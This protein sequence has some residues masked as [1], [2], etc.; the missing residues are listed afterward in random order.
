MRQIPIL[1]LALA[2]TAASADIAPDALWARWQSGNAAIAA[3]EGTV[4]QTDAGLVVEGAVL[5]LGRGPEAPRLLA[6]PLRLTAEDG[7]TRITPPDT[8]RIEGADAAFEVTAPELDL[9]VSGTAEAP[10]YRIEEPMLEATGRLTSGEAAT[11]VTLSADDLLAEI[12]PAAGLVLTAAD[13][14]LEVAPETGGESLSAA[15][16]GL[17]VAFE[18]PPRAI[19]AP[20]TEGVTY[21]MSLASEASRH[22]LDG[23]AGAAG[24]VRATIASGPA[25]SSVASSEARI[26]ALQSLSQVVVTATGAGLPLPEARVDIGALSL[27]VSTP[28]APVTEAA[29]L[30]LDLAITG[31]SPAEEIWQLLDPGAALPRAPAELRLSVTGDLSWL[32]GTDPAIP[33]VERARLDALRLSALGATLTG[34]GGVQFQPPATPETPGRPLGA[35]AFT[36]TGA[37]A[38]LDRLA[39]LQSIPRDQILGLRM[40][41]G[42]FTRP[43]EGAD[44]LVS[45]IEFAPDG[46][47]VING[48]V[49]GRQP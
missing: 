47:I 27:G 21:A 40:G 35:L 26:E 44:E 38:L 5:R 1:V 33:A 16:E 10:L 18:G 19:F 41:L 45:R 8:W 7:T 48:T 4:R 17:H 23:P 46:A 30:S 32:A 39:A 36:L 11:G 9:R 6:D 31:L 24:R 2:G 12:D 29:P 22:V 37:H 13:A 25:R 34:Q 14:A 49:I 42:L 28:A 15:W 20:A 3:L 43:G